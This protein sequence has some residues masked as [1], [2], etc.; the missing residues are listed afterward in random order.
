[1]D[2]PTVDVERH[3]DGFAELAAIGC[4]WVS[5]GSGPMA[6]PELLEW[7]QAFGETY[8]D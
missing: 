8:C 1:M 5:V 7:V 4:E 3:R 6:P 2:Q